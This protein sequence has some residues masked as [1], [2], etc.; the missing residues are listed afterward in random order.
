MAASEARLHSSTRCRSPARACPGSGARLGSTG[1]APRISG[2][3]C[4][5]KSVQA[6]AKALAASPALATSRATAS[7][8]PTL[9]LE[10]AA[11]RGAAASASLRTPAA[12]ASTRPA[13]S[14]TRR[15]ARSSS[16]RCLRSSASRRS[17]SRRCC[18]L[19]C[20]MRRRACSRPLSLSSVMRWRWLPVFSSSWP[21]TSR[22]SAWSSSKHSGV[23][24]RTF[25][26]TLRIAS[27]ERCSWRRFS[28]ASLRFLASSSLRRRSSSA[29]RS[30]SSRRL[31]ASSSR[32]RSSSARRRSSSSSR[33]RA[34]WCRCICRRCSASA[35]GASWPGPAAPLAM[36]KDASTGPS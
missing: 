7:T 22:S 20:S 16:S 4:R 32:R 28:S 3:C 29:W 13:S 8:S 12:A 11:S 33:R 6:L 18:S 15:R 1:P 27:V 36:R 35:R 2:P 14:A 21:S 10:S 9:S 24:T 23:A 30:A 34:S 17:C 25:W 26:M 5:A 19:S 31:R